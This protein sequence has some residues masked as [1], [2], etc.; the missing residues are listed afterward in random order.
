VSSDLDLGT[1]WRLRLMINRWPIPTHPPSG[2][3]RGKTNRNTEPVTATVKRI[4]NIGGSYGLKNSM[5]R[6]ASSERT[7]LA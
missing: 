6:S 1:S 5:A 2:D 7:Q 4:T 3:V